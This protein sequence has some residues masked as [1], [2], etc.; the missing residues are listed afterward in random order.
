MTK[1]KPFSQAVV[2]SPILWGGLACAG[3]YTLVFGGAIDHPMVREYFA[4]HPVEYV[5]TAMF[6]I[7]L[8]ALVLK[9]MDVSRQSQGVGRPVLGSVP[10]GGQPVSEC[11]DLAAKLGRLPGRQQYDYLIRRLRDA[12]EYV[13]RTGSSEGLDEELRYL[14]DLDANRVHAGYGLVRIIIWAI[15]ILG[16]LGTVIG[17]AL[18]M[19]KLAPQDLEQSLP[20]VMASLTIAFNTTILALGLSIVLMFAQFFCERRENALLAEVDHR[21]Y[22]E[23][24]GRFERIAAGPDGELVAVRRMIEA[25]LH[26]NEELVNRQTELWWSTVEAAQQ[27]WTAMT[28]TAGTQLQTALAGALAENLKVHAA[29]LV[30]N[31]QSYAEANRRQWEKMQAALTEN[32]STVAGLQEA[33]IQKAEVLARAVESTDQVGRLQHALN[34]NLGA[35]AGSKNFE[36]T[37]MSLAAAIHLLNSRLGRMPSDVPM[38]K[39]DSNPRAGQAA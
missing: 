17:I 2:G 6:F 28:E 5:T 12:L 8:A 9:L 25:I 22:S 39:L 11:D 33:V 31:E 14:A 36:E 27:R 23:M 26:A 20:T 38:V 19:G 18:A 34:E 29:E 1:P 4:S 16:F 24:V 32:T 21:V 3:F 13:R 35:L 37:V 15:P 30:A 10:Q 7:G